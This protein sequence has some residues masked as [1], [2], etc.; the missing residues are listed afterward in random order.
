MN[1]TAIHVINILI[2]VITIGLSLFFTWGVLAFG[3]DGN[4]LILT[5]PLVVILVW[6]AVYYLQV[7]FN[8][9]KTFILLLVVELMLL[10]IVFSFIELN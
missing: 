4:M 5:L 7:K 6:S 2:G 8:S 10:F 1:K 9:I 3:P